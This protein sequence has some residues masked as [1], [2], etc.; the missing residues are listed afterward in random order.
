M[1]QHCFFMLQSVSHSLAP[2]NDSEC[3]LK[4]LLLPVNFQPKYEVSLKK[5][6]VEMISSSLGIQA[7]MV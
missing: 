4:W 7:L 3:Y 6:D 2:E 1:F 5:K